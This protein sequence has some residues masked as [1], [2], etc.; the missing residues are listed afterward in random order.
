MGSIRDVW[1]EG[2]KR[3]RKSLASAPEYIE[4]RHEIKET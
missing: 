3:G 4:S 1:R 2:V